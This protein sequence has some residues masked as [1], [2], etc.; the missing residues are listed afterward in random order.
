MSLA[1]CL[2]HF[3]E[4]YLAQKTVPFRFIVDRYSRIDLS[5]IKSNYTGLIIDQLESG[6]GSLKLE[7]IDEIERDCKCKFKCDPSYKDDNAWL[8]IVSGVYIIRSQ[9]HLELTNLKEIGADF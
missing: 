9:S 1:N 5:S 4:K 2:Y 7:V 8:A 3:F 6:Y